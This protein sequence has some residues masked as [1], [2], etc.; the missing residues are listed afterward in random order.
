MF[1]EFTGH[2]GLNNINMCQPCL[3]QL[4]E[5]DVVVNQ[6][7]YISQRSKGH[8]IMYDRLSNLSEFKRV[9]SICG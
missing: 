6:F 8:K 3:A 1:V 9:C 7:H 4:V 2:K 5:V